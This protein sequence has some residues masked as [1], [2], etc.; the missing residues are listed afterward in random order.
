MQLSRRHFIPAAAVIV[1]A[2]VLLNVSSAPADPARAYQVLQAPPPPPGPIE[3]VEFFWYS[4]PHCYEFE[5]ALRDWAARH[6][7]DIVLR[8]VPVGMRPQQL[9]QQR[10]F[11]VM[12]ALGMGEDADRELF[13]QIHEADKPLDTQAALATF[14]AGAGVTPQRFNAAWQSPGVQ[15]RVDEA[16]RLH[17]AMHVTM[18]P[19]VV[20]GGRYV[21]SPA[22]L[23]A[24]MPMWGQTVAGSHEAT[25]KMM[26]TLLH[27]ARQDS[28]AGGTGHERTARSD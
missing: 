2:A 23:S 20:I 15:R 28:M 22:M 24:T 14:A 18:V 11:Y 21:T 27:R 13:R 4:C 7:R 9:P 16:T 19:T 17:Q 5:P 25:V 26:D 1:G 8:R 3:V 12:E 10:M 6:R